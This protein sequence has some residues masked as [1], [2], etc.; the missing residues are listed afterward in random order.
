ML[1][2]VQKKF[3]GA[4]GISSDQLFGTTQVWQWCNRSRK[5]VGRNSHRR[6]S[7]KKAIL[8]NFAIFT[9]KH[10]CWNL[11]LIK[12]QA[13]QV[14]SFEYCKILK[15]T[16]FEE[17]LQTVASALLL[18]HFLVSCFK[19]IIQAKGLKGFDHELSQI[20]VM[21]C[22]HWHH[23]YNLKTKKTMKECCFQWSCRLYP[24]I[25][26][27]VTL[28]DGCFLRFLN[29]TNGTKSRKAS[30]LYLEV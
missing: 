8:K 14:F 16:N 2:E 9:K 19:F 13:T 4:K 21:L 17:H 1:D 15:N 12:L 28:F 5:L 11:F 25:L 30:H 18:M 27:K 10:L 24:A 29:C 22:L 7:R 6:C 23:L 26:I 20:F 3:G